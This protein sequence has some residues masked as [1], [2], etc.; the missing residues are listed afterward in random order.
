MQVL[1]PMLGDL[2][3]YSSVVGVHSA[4]RT[5]GMGMQLKKRVWETMGSICLEGDQRRGSQE[6]CC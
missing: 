4:L 1:H 5:D 6:V 2:G 3:T